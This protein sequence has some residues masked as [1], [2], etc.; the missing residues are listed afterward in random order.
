MHVLYQSKVNGGC[1]RWY[2][3]NR[4]VLV[5]PHSDAIRTR[6]EHER[7]IADFI[8]FLGAQ[9]RFAQR[10]FAHRF[11]AFRRFFD[12]KASVERAKHTA[13]KRHGIMCSTTIEEI[14]RIE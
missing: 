5:S 2:R 8:K 12:R 4:S 3:V 14:E 7:G 10:D 9:I 13:R 11:A 1:S 6:F